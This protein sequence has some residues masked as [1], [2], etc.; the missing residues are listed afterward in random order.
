MLYRTVYVW[1][2][3]LEPFDSARDYERYGSA[4]IPVNLVR[5]AGGM[6]GPLND[7]TSAHG[8]DIRVRWLGEKL[9]LRSIA[10]RDRTGQL[11]LGDD[12]ASTTYRASLVGAASR[13]L[14]IDGRGARS[15]AAIDPT[16]I[17]FYS[18]DEYGLA[19]NSAF[20]AVDSLLYTSFP[21]GD[22]ITRGVRAYHAQANHGHA[23]QHQ[24]TSAGEITV[25]TYIGDVRYAYFDPAQWYG[26]PESIRQAPAIAQH[27]GG[28]FG[29]PLLQLDGAG[30]ALYTRAFQRLQVGAYNTG[31]DR[32]PYDTPPKWADELGHAAW[33]SRRTG[34]RII[35]WPG[36]HSPLRL[37]WRHD[38]AGRHY[39][40]TTM[41]HLN[42][43]SEIRMAVNLGLC[44]GSRGVSYSWIGSAINEFGVTGES[45][46]R[47]DGATHYDFYTDFGPVGSR[48][49][50]RGNSLPR[51]ELANT[52]FNP[53]ARFV[54]PSFYTGWDNRLNEMKW[55][56]LSWLP[57]MGRAMARL[58]WRDGYSMHFAVTQ[59]YMSDNSGGLPQ[60]RSRPFPDTLIVRGIESADRRGLKDAPAETYVELG[61]F[62][63]WPGMRSG[64]PDPA[65]DTS[66]IF[67]LNRRTFERPADIAAASD[68]GRVMDSLA[69]VRTLRITFNMPRIDPSPPRTIRVREIA[70][71]LTP[72]PGSSSP[73]VP[74]DTV[75]PGDGVVEL[76]L[77]PGGGALLEITGE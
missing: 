11:L 70:P 62:D 38:D 21:T 12:P 65:G 74:L 7:A 41:T 44:Y 19:E 23:S 5:Y 59:S 22:S 76:T 68:S 39:V 1:K 67:V 16:I 58:R 69:E 55:L 75:I 20:N 9:A 42:E 27:N 45:G 33:S 2:E 18:G 54:I 61:L 63:P 30:V 37:E 8:I 72:L 48:V 40:D 34:R 6:G 56:N 28:R 52:D 14:H 60:T 4:T 71:D 24:L 17:R 31:Y 15:L 25:E 51:F 13:A 10:L 64:A 53:P 29:I 73:R 32:W 46:G 77:R 57:R 35:Q 50:I 36:V 26:L 3:G 47:W 66:H 43:A 49:G